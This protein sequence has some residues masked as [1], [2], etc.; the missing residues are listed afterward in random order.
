MYDDGGVEMGGWLER[1][2]FKK[3]GGV[4]VGGEAGD[5]VV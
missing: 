3:V 5:R 4:R 2:I 1:M